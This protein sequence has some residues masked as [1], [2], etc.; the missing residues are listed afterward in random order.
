MRSILAWW[1]IESVRAL[2]GG[3][4]GRSG[5]VEGEKLGGGLAIEPGVMVMAGGSGVGRDGELGDE[6]ELSS[7]RRE[8]GEGVRVWSWIEGLRAESGV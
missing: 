6:R 3:V 2:R 5:D 8:S 1:S 4:G 7:E